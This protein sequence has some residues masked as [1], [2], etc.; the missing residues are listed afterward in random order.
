[1]LFFGLKLA[2]QS[3]LLLCGCLQL[4]L[5]PDNRIPLFL[6]GAGRCLLQPG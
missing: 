2:K 3:C 4:C 5:Q 6:L 1:M